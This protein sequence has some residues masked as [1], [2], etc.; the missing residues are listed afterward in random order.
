M[1]G[2]PPKVMTG[3]RAQVMV[4]SKIIGTLSSFSYNL[5]FDTQDANILGSL[6][7]AEI[8]YVGVEPCSGT[9]GG[10]AVLDHGAFAEMGLPKVQ[11]LLTAP[12]TQIAVF[13]RVTNE[14]VGFVKQVRLLG[15]SGGYSARQMAENTV[16]YR[17]IFYSDET[18]DNTERPDA[19]RFP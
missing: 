12:Y 14:R 9:M 15:K 13:D 8:G 19:S 6:V 4:G 17:G 2:T 1:A 7:P 18:A 11:D 3:A 16:P 5:Q 10:W